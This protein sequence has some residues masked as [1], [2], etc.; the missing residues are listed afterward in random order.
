[1][2]QQSGRP[3]LHENFYTGNTKGESRHR[4]CPTLPAR[5][6][7]TSPLQTSPTKSKHGSLLPTAVPPSQ[8]RESIAADKKLFVNSLAPSKTKEAG[9][10]TGF[11]DPLQN[12]ANA[13]KAS[14]KNQST[15]KRAGHSSNHAMTEARSPA[16]SPMATKKSE[17]K[18]HAVPS[19]DASSGE[20]K[21]YNKGTKEKGLLR[22]GASNA[23]KAFQNH[24]NA[25]SLN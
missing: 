7:T 17:R 10:P 13:Q 1:M 22:T 12:G 21:D 11:G 15:S 6:Y 5:N 19:E 2:S 18:H 3:T 8:R 14:T 25:G 9:A 23:S 20:R 16:T 4:H 24:S